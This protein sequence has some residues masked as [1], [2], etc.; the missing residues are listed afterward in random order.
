MSVVNGQYFRLDEIGSSIWDLLQTP[1]AIGTLCGQLA[2]QY[3]VPLEQ[4][5][6]DVLNLLQTMLERQ[7]IC[8]R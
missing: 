1:T 2:E 6:A 3:D 7:L 8:V 4:C 5:E